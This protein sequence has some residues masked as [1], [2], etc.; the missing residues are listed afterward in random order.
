M[1]LKYYSPDQHKGEILKTVSPS[2]MENNHLIVL[3]KCGNE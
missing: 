3:D 1:D 2:R